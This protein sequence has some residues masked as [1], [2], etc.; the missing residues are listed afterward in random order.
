MEE[1]LQRLLVLKS[2][3]ILDA[4][5]EEAFERL[6]ALGGRI[7]NVPI[8]LV[9]LV[10]IGRQW[11]MSNMGL[12]LC[13]QTNRRVAFCAHAI[14]L[15][16]GLNTLVVRDARTD[17]RFQDSPLVLGPP[18]IRFYAGAPLISPE[19]FKVRMW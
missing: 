9:S 13:R 2:Y 11:F 4:E 16:P 6:T 19:G 14:Q 8:C 10:D 15:K 3:L 17:F 5:R 12:G 7:F 18:F 1:E